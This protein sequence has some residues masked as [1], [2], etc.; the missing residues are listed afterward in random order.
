MSSTK[1]V[2]LFL[3]TVLFLNTLACNQKP[4]EHFPKK[5]IFSK[6]L[7]EMLIIQYLKIKEPEKAA[8][9]KDV[10]KKYHLSKKEFEITKARYA[11]DP[12]FWAEIFKRMRKHLEEE[13]RKLQ[14]ANKKLPQKAKHK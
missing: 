4:K 14:K 11:Q 1:T 10:L 3:A 2:I 13:N 6:A 7:Q 9:V 12:E 5:E 8:L